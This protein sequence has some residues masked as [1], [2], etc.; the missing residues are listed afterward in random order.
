MARFLTSNV[1]VS[2]GK[3]KLFFAVNLK[4]KLFRATVANSNTGNLKTLHTLFDTYLDHM[5]P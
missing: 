4:I 2:N 5:L 3:I 1:K